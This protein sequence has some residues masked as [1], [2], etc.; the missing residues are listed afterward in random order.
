MSKYTLCLTEPYF[1]YFHGDM[2]NRNS[3]NNL[4][5]QFLCQETF[6]LFEFYHDEECWQEYI[7]HMENW[8]NFA[9]SRGEIATND[10]VQ[11]IEHPI[12][13]N[14]WKLHR[15]KHYCQLNIA[16]TYETETG[17]MMC[18]LKTFWIS[19]FQRKFR[20]YIAKKKKIIRLRKCPKQLFHR[21]IYGK[22]KKNISYI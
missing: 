13:K 7:Y 9:Y 2:E 20:N 17:E 15:N 5:G 12:I 11:P 1:S 8:L 4:N 18:V 19:I 3:F 14:F 21:S 22:W 10:T 6:D 16:K